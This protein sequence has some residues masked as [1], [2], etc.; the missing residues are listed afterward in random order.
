ML[1]EDLL[2]AHQVVSWLSPDERAA[3]AG[4]MERLPLPAPASCRGPLED[5]RRVV[6]A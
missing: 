2:I 1:L 3:L 6:A 4:L 5:L